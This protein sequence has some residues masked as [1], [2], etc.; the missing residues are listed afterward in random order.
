M[1]LIVRSR[2]RAA[3]ATS[4]A[5][6]QHTVGGSRVEVEIDHGARQAAP[7][8]AAFRARADRRPLALALDERSVFADQQLEMGA[9]L[10]GELEE[11]PLAFRVLELARR[12][13]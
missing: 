3:R 4:A 11:D 2:S 8:R 5:G 12:I 10:V 6:A 9:L 13:A 7:A 1:T